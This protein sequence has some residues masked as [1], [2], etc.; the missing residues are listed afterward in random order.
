[1]REQ[2][3]CGAKIV[4]SKGDLVRLSQAHLANGCCGLKFVH[5]GRA[6][7][8]AETCHPFGNCTARYQHNLLALLAQ[9][10]NL[11]SPLCNGFSIQAFAIVR[12]KGR[13]H[14][15]HDA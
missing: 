7:V 11:S 5:R 10:G 4:F 8:P 2:N 9:G 15:G 3:L 6:L 13:A 14:L 1:M 12:D